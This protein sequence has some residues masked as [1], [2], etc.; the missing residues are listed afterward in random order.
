[1]QEFRV[2]DWSPRWLVIDIT[3]T[4][5]ERCAHCIV[6]ASPLHKNTIEEANLMLGVED[7]ERNGLSSVSF[8]GG[9][10]FTRKQIL[11]SWVRETLKRWMSPQI[12]TNGFWWV[13]NEKIDTILS[14]LEEMS[15]D[16]WWIPISLNISTDEFHTKV[17]LKSLANII[18]RWLERN[19]V[20][21]I[22]IGLSVGTWKT[23]QNDIMN[24]L[25][26]DIDE[27]W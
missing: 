4:C 5:N 25:W 11:Y 16:S 10:P 6:A 22:Y 19:D 1:M 15:R 23:D 13:N 20:K 8:Y 21:N 3:R 24:K 26:D 2:E 14:E 12:M 27:R 18:H 9:E 17:P 7:A